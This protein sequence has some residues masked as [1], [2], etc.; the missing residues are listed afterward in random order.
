[1]SAE[2]IYNSNVC[3][4]NQNDGIKIKPKACKACGRAIVFLPTSKG[5]YIPV[6]FESYSGETEFNSQVHVA[7]FSDC[8]QAKEFRKVKK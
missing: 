2:T 4:I 8:P 6:N 5:K 7:H 3:G 1:M